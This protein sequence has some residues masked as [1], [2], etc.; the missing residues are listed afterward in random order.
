F[1]GSPEITSIFPGSTVPNIGAAYPWSMNLQNSI[2]D[3]FTVD[4][5]LGTLIINI[6]ITLLWMIYHK[7]RLRI[8]DLIFGIL[9]MFLFPL[10]GII[11]LP[12][13][14]LVAGAPIGDYSQ[15][16]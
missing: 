11:I 6:C 2:I 14:F 1:F 8:I 12:I 3:F 15:I 7:Q 10:I 4:F 16:F 9:G 13:S 5:F